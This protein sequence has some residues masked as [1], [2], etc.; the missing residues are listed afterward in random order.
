MTDIAERT[1]GDLTFCD[2]RSRWV[3][4]DLEPH[5][6]Q[7]FKR[8][9]PKVHKMA[10][11]ITLFD[12]DETRADLEWFMLRYPLRH[13]FSKALAAGAR[14]MARRAAEIGRILAPDWTPPDFDGF[15]E[16][17]APYL[18]QSQASAVAIAQGSLLLG[19]D[20]GLG[21]TASVIHAGVSGAPLP[22]AIVVQPHLPLQWKRQIERFC[23]G[24]VHIIAS[25]TPYELPPADFYIFRYTNICGWKDMFKKLKFPSVAWDEIQELRRGSDTDKGSASIALRDHSTF[26]MGTSATPIF[27]YGDE[28]H[29]VMEYITPGLLGDKEEF[30]REWCGG[31]AIVKDPDALGSFLKESGYFL[32]RVETDEVVNRSL[33]PLN[34]LDYE[35]ACDEREIENEMEILRVLA[36]TVLHGNF[37]DAGQASRALDLRLRQLTGIGKARYV[38]AYVKMLLRDT[39]KVVIAAWHREV[40]DI[41]LRT[42]AEFEP[43][44]YTGTETTTKKD[45]HAQAFIE[46]GCRVLLMS[47]RSGAGL[48][49]LQHVCNDAVLGEFDWSPAV[50]KQFFGRFRRPG[51]RYQV[52]AHHLWTNFGSDPVM[53]E[54]LGVK[55]DQLRGINDPGQALAA[56][57]TD[58]SRVKM[59]AE[60]VLEKGG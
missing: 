51:Q 33:P 56:R 25:R 58:D 55:T 28:M 3:I 32:R 46:G 22:M 52:N 35:I 20:V 45:R 31:G 1:Y 24:R 53:M 16:G 41:Y 59:L 42:L 13:R 21:K 10:D 18:Y 34:V 5:V 9:F 23:R 44:L 54:M 43:L 19:D 17:E 60:Y 47:L 36:T 12:N 6:A 8:L 57:H 30:K 29:N 14:R 49:G 2:E 26:R 38:A 4:S 11:E 50:H 39:E 48:D 40:Y 37:V 27:N 15:R 7:A